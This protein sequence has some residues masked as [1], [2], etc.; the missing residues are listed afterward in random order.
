MGTILSS[1][2]I[3]IPK[4]NNTYYIGDSVSGWINNIDLEGKDCRLVLRLEAVGK[5]RQKRKAAK[6]ELWRLIEKA[7]HTNTIWKR[8]EYRF[9]FE[10]KEFCWKKEEI[11]LTPS[12]QLF[13]FKWLVLNED[14]YESQWF[15]LCNMRRRLGKDF[16]ADIQKEQRK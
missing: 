1:K 14:A 3:Y 2:T 16:L 5:S 10:A 9:L 12:E 4:E 6:E 13:L 8:G 15:Y 11:Y 7:N